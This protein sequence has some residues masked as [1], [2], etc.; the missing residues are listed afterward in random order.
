VLVVAIAVLLVQA[1]RNNP[2]TI[3]NQALSN[4]LT[5]KQVQEAVSS[6]AFNATLVLDTSNPKDPR[7]STLTTKSLGANTYVKG[8]GSLQNTYISYASDP[9]SSTTTPTNLLDQWIQ[10][11]SGGSLSAGATLNPLFAASDPRYQVVSSWVFSGFS[12]KDRS[13]LLKLAK[14]SKLYQIDTKKITR[15]SVNSHA[16]L[17]YS[18]AVNGGKLAAYEARA[19]ALFGIA[20]SDIATITQSLGGS[21]V[22][23]K[24]YVQKDTR[25]VVRVDATVRGLTTRATYS[26][27]NTAKLPAEPKA[28]LSYSAYL[29]QLGS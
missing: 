25:Q 14:S 23:L 24:V 5:T 17:V 12:G 29:K 4:S 15:T 2:A 16:A 20:K 13:S 19:G 28:G 9:T 3:F 26:D 18:L 1:Y 10:V 11:R 7:L 6:D 8:Y 27:F 22:G 21:T